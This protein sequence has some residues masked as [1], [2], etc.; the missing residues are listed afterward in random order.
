MV[1]NAETGDAPV[2]KTKEK[3][4]GKIVKIGLAGAI[5]DIGTEHKAMLHIS[6]IKSPT[7]EPIN[8]AEDVL[9]VGQEVQVWVRRIKDDRI[10]LTMFEPLALEWREIK[11]GMVVKGI[12]VKLENFGAFVE[13][14]AERPGLIHISE[15]AHG[16]IHAPS[17]VL[18]EGQEIEAEVLEVNRRK[19]QIKL[20]MKA[21]EPLEEE[22]LDL[23]ES[24][25]EGK[26]ANG[27]ARRR[28]KAT[29]KKPGKETD[30]KEKS[31]EKE[32]AEKEA[33]TTMGSALREAMERAKGSNDDENNK[34]KAKEEKTSSKEQDDILTR[35]LEHRTPPS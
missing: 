10:D 13:I 15:I 28:A 29:R 19:K 2:I 4:K 33:E 12:I 23:A 14:G 24:E 27:K 35:T 8:R 1:T 7:E 32:A 25:G 30:A 3:L 20:S 34:D 18:S 21:L 22:E 9:E 26:A 11:K 17:D 16:Y 31:T 5:V 6:Q